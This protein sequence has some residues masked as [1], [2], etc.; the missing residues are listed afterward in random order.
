MI[1]DLANLHETAATNP[2][3]VHI[4]LLQ[5]ISQWDC[6]RESLQETIGC[7]YLSSSNKQQVFS[8]KI[9]PSHSGKL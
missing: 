2:E 7:C 3:I 6:L 9:F 8:C 5:I 4:W 1:K